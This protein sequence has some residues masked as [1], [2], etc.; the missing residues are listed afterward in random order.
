MPHSL[1]KD[2]DSAEDALIQELLNQAEARLQSSISPAEKSLTTAA[3]KDV[4]AK[5]PALSAGTGLKSYVQREGEISV[6]NPAQAAPHSVIQ[7]PEVTFPSGANQASQKKEDAGSDWFNLPKTKMTPELKREF[8][9]LRMRNVLDPKRHYKK[10]AGNNIPEYSQVGTIVEGPAE[11]FKSRVVKKDRKK[12]FLEEAL[13]TE[14]EYGRFKSKYN[15][16]QTAKT[17]G[18]KAHYNRLQAKRRR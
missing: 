3:P 17:S 5:L 8:Q 6:L 10:D 12:T 18:K 13:A 1:L 4:E 7:P 2:D 16:I 14:N 9:L 15:Q 11:F